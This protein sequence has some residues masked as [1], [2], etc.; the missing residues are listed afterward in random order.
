MIGSYSVALIL[1]AIIN[2]SCQ[3]FVDP[4]WPIG[5]PSTLFR[6]AIGTTYMMLCWTALYFGIKYYESARLQREAALKAENLAREATL[7]ALRY[8][9]NP[10]FLFNTLNSISTLILDNQVRAATLAVSQLSQLLRY[11]LD[12]DPMK[13]VA[14]HEELDALELYLSAERLRLGSR[15]RI[16]YSIDDAARDALVPSL[17]FQPVVENAISH[18]IFAAEFGGVLRIHCS[19]SGAMLRIRISGHVQT[20]SRRETANATATLNNVRSRLALMY[21]EYQCFVVTNDVTGLAV[22]ISLP[23][24][25]KPVA[26]S[27][28][29]PRVS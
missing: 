19:V 6:G 16:D 23:Y 9:L 28:R 13:K 20:T 2:F 22:S 14:L 1:R 10:H 3:I 8:Q 21:G 12:Q 4:H 25:P 7:K 18:S 5:T 29:A 26:S 27:L 24:E 11:T 17:V 15:L